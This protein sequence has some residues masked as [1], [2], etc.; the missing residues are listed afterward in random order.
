MQN[1]ISSYIYLIQDAKDKGTQV[2]KIGRTSQSMD[3]RNLARLNSYSKNS[4]TYNISYIDYEYVCEVE[5]KIKQLF[6]KKY[7]RVRGCEWFEGNWR[8]MKKDIDGIINSYLEMKPKLIMTR[9][10]SER[11]R[12][13]M[14]CTI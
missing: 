6:N 10:R 1:H 9:S 5:K 12:Q 3:T 11:I 4:V 14:A 7:H 8:D 2:Y 13:T